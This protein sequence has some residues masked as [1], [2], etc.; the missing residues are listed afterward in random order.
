MGED[1]SFRFSEGEISGSKEN[2]LDIGVSKNVIPISPFP[3]L[4]SSAVLF[5]V[6]YV[7][8]RCVLYICGT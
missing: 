7:V 3:P 8:D 5:F 6:K 2:F 1:K 4:E